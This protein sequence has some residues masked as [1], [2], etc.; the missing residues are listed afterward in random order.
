LFLPLLQLE[1][2]TQQQ[3]EFFR[4]HILSNATQG[5]KLYHQLDLSGASRY[6]PPLLAF[7]LLHLADAVLRF[8]SKD[9]SSLDVAL[10][11]IRILETNRQGFPICGPLLQ[12]FR[13][14]VRG[15]EFQIPEEVESQLGPADQFDVDGI[16][17]AATRLSYQQPLHQIQQW[18]DDAFGEEWDNEWQQR[19]RWRGGEGPELGAK[20]NS[21]QIRD[22]LNS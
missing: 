15:L 1:S 20:R 16:L 9:Q 12:M 5:L 7:C 11:S 14:T 8:G 3:R 18:I 6:Q 22:V 19:S 17:D 13:D 2:V 21:M 10:F 4:Q